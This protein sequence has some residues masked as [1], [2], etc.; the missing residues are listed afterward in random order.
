MRPIRTFKVRP[1]LPPSLLPL[2][3]VA[4]NLRWS[5]DH[6]A[7]ELFRRLDRDLC[8]DSAGCTKWPVRLWLCDSSAA[9][10]LRRADA[11]CAGI[12]SVGARPHGGGARISRA[13]AI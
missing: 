13:K 6:A 7:I 2:L 1:S 12:D 11:V 10:A 4:Y 5:W 8:G 9:Q 3:E